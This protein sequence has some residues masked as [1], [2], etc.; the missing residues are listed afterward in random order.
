MENQKIVLEK[1]KYIMY[2]GMYYCSE[3]RYIFNL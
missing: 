1:I 3:I 2:Q